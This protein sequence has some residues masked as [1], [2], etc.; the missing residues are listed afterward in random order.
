MAAKTSSTRGRDPKT[1]F[2]AKRCTTFI[3]TPLLQLGQVDTLVAD[4]YVAAVSIRHHAGQSGRLADGILEVAGLE[5][6]IRGRT[7]QQ[8][9]VATGKDRAAVFER[10]ATH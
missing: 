8:G 7:R 3:G 5:R 2:S 6:C 4:Q 9:A 1:H 10:G